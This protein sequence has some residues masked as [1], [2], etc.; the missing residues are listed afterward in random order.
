[1]KTV[2]Y[3]NGA[4]ARVLFSHARHC[5]D[6]AG[7]T[8]GDQFC[9]QDSFCGLPLVPFSNVEAVFDPRG[10]T[11]ITA[12][13]F[14]DMNLLR[15]QRHR[16]ASDKGYR[17]ERYV[18]P[19]VMHHDGVTIEEDTIVLDHVSIHPGCRIGRGTFI[20][21]NVNIGHD[22]MI[23]DYNWINSGVAIAGGCHVGRSCFFG[24]NS[25]LTEGVALGERNFIGAN[26]MINR[27]TANDSVHLSEAGAL[28]RLPSRSFLK[29]SGMAG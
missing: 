6:I 26:T 17:F 11:M 7:F 2:I 23:S 9:T 29:F 18:H 5:L 19:S 21:S 14:L 1:M 15:E 8:V 3:G 22:C 24:V 4:M 16:Q 13:G 25:C 10:C 12:V 20:S 28:F 27:K